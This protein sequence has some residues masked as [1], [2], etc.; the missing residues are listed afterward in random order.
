MQFSFS[1]EQRRLLDQ[2]LDDANVGQAADR[3]GPRTG[4]PGRAPLSFGQ[5]RL[6]LVDRLQPGSPM[7]VGTGALRL[8]GSLDP[9]VLERCFALLVERHEVLRTAIGESPETGE[10]EQRILGTDEVTVRVPVREVTRDELQATVTELTSEGFDLS[11]PPLLRAVLLKVSD[12]AQ[13][14]WVLVLSVH[15]IVV[16]GWSMGLMMGELGEAYTALSQ[17]RTAGLPPLALQYADFAA[18]QRGTL[19]QG[20]LDGQLQYWRETLDGV[21]MVE[22]AADRPRPAQRGYAGDTVPLRLPPAVA[23]G[24][25]TLTDEVQATLF[26]ALVAGWSVVLGRWS[27]ETDVVVGTPVAGRRRAE[28]ESIAGFFVNTLPLRVGLKAGDD[29][30]ALLRRTRDVCVDAYAHQD[31]SF[32]RIVAEVPAERDVSGQTTLARHW[33]V[34]HNTPPLAFSAPGLEAE[35]LPSLVGTVRCDLSVQL[36]P[37]EDGGL[38]GWLEYST[39]LFDRGTAERLAAAL[40][41]V[42][43]AAAETPGGMVRELPVMPREEYERAV[44][45]LAAAPAVETEHADVVAWFE[46]QADRTPDT[47]AVIAD[48]DEAG[49]VAG[50]TL[51]YAELDR[52]ANRVAHLLAGLGVGPEDRVGICLERGADLVAAVLGVLKAGAVH[53]PLDPEYPAARLEQLVG[54]GAPRTVLTG[55][56]LDKLFPGRETVVVPEGGLTGQP[57]HRLASGPFASGQAAALLFTSGSTGRPKG[58]VLTH[59]GLLN[60]LAGMREAYGI[61]ADDRTLQKAPIGFD[62]SLWELLLP[63]VCG[64]AVVHARPGG[65]RDADYLHELIDRHGVT[66]CHF[67]PSMLREFIASADAAGHPTVR[68]YFS[69]GEKLSAELAGQCL[70]RYPAARLFNQYGPTEAVIDV[71]AGQVRQPVPAAVPIGRPVPGTELLVLDADGRP[72]PTGVPGE[73]FIGGV[74]LARGYLGSPALTAERFVP[75]PFAPGERLYATGDRVRRLADGSLE[76]LGRGDSQVK[77]RGHRVETGE[78]ES[79]LRRHPAVTDAVVRVCVDDTGQAQLIGY[80]TTGTEEAPEGLKAELRE[81]LG[82]LLPEAMVPAHL[83]VLAQWPLNAHGKVDTAALPEPDGRDSGTPYEAPRTPLEERLAE[84]CAELLDVERLGRHDSFFALGGH[85]LLA[86]RAIS[87]IRAEF[88]VRVQIGQFFKAPDLASLAGLVAAKQA[89]A[90]AAPSETAPISRID[91]RRD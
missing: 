86:L 50:E 22:V 53:L 68:L 77:V 19:E 64:A 39:E 41:T 72:Q 18:W 75:H 32:E 42:L 69:G 76:F 90:E 88:G 80:V 2:M 31:V 61:G 14:E 33:L 40:T 83:P 21:P 20:R 60:R 45:A 27:G 46:A 1:A 48:G 54:D 87:R 35:L 28:L 29:F 25:H 74:Q 47:T 82:G 3:I 5:E 71:T 38:D 36:L 51:T 44:S 15:H 89:Q 65:H 49:T 43:T 8:R 67:V 6:F 7:Y 55:P 17:G 78:V 58:V 81:L 12:A 16:D 10:P 24:L 37:E 84:L 56:G 4:D 34:L 91:R 57:D 73:L 9:G 52:R 26:M 70:D 30:R 13:P 63:V 62:V 11:R 79:A 59:G 23:K 85:S 66:I